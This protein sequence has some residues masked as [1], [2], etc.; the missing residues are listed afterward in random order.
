MAG[1]PIPID[2]LEKLVKEAKVRVQERIREVREL[3]VGL[4]DRSIGY[5]R[6]ANVIR[7]LIIALGA[8]LATRAIADSYDWSTHDNL[9]LAI[10]LGYTAMSVMVAFVAGLQATYKPGER[11]TEVEFLRVRCNHLIGEIQYRW[12]AKVQPLGVSN[13][14]LEI[15]NELLNR[16]NHEN[17]QIETRLAQ[18]RV[19]IKRVPLPTT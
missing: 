3:D 6:Q 18:L 13:E 8:L 14:A 15:A 2:E 17:T 5:F 7:I 19:P 1:Q 16:L 4:G 12:A 10:E 9:R 11:A